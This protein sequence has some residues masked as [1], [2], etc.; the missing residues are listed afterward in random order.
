MWRGEDILGGG[1]GGGKDSVFAASSAL[2][3]E[4]KREKWWSYKCYGFP[5]KNK[6][7]EDSWMR[8]KAAGERSD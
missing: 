3:A 2:A 6:N 8:R 5:G 1:G 7:Q 4:N